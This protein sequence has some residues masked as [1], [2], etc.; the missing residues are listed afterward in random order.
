[1]GIRI[2]LNNLDNWTKEYAKSFKACFTITYSKK[3]L[4]KFANDRFQNIVDEQELDFTDKEFKNYKKIF[5][6]TFIDTMIEL[7]EE[8]AKNLKNKKKIDAESKNKKSN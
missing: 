4:E 6:K 2:D 3:Y 7:I 1:M 8:E 5:V